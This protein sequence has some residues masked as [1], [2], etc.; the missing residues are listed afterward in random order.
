MHERLRICKC[1][2]LNCQSEPGIHQ[3]RGLSERP[4]PVVKSVSVCLG[5]VQ[6]LLLWLM[7]CAGKCSSLMLCTWGAQGAG[8]LSLPGGEYRH[9]LADTVSVVE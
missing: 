5:L 4:G 2:S 7:T 9:Q 6:A 3:P 8:C 1:R